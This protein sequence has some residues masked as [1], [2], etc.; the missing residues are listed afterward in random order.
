[1]TNSVHDRL[2][3]LALADFRMKA[4]SLMAF[5]EE[6]RQRLKSLVLNRLD[7]LIDESHTAEEHNSA[8]F[9]TI[10]RFLVHL[11]E[12]TDLEHLS[13]RT[14][15][16]VV[17]TSLD[18]PRHQPH[19]CIRLPSLGFWDDRGLITQVEGYCK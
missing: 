10:I 13:L 6:H 3:R 17:T 16:C 15:I 9:R 1:M 7:I 5:L 12:T 8:A 11:R 14:Q 19:P 2:E 18:H 4:G